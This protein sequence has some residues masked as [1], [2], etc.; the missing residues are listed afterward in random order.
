LSA[1][2]AGHINAFL[3]R[4]FKYGFCNTIYTIGA[5]AEETDNVLF[6]KVMSANHCIP[7]VKSNGYSLIDK[8]YP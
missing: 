7:P 3:K 1:E 2:M 4:A 8:G 6:K 5:I